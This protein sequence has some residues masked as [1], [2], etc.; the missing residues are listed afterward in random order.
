MHK[1]HFV[2]HHIPYSLYKELKL[3][4]P[5]I[6]QCQQK[7]SQGDQLTHWCSIKLSLQELVYL[8][9]IYARS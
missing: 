2:R 8:V 4:V 3:K 7:P 6:C 9:S 5:K 1:I